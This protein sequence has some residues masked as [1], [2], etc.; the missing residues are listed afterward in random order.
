MGR[1]ERDSLGKL[2]VPDGVYYGIQT[3]RAIQNF[4]VSG[5]RERPELIH[6]YLLLKKAA[7]GT[8]VELGMLDAE[9]SDTPEHPIAREAAAAVAF[10]EDSI[11]EEQQIEA[12]P[13]F[14]RSLAILEKALGP[15]HPQVA[16]I[17]RN[18]AEYY[19]KTGKKKEAKRLEERAKIIET[20]NLLR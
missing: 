18:M 3:A 12:E 10:T 11:T 13:L 2:E 17:L 8:N 14:K 9:E 5:M 15:E 20:K 19:K 16:T 6:A 1:I 4:P 7:A